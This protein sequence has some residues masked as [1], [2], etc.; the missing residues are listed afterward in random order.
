[1]L[2]AGKWGKQT[3]SIF[4]IYS[5]STAALV[6]RKCLS[7]MLY[8]HVFC[9]VIY[10]LVGCVYMDWIGLVQDRDR[11][12]T[13]VSAVMNLRV[14]WN[15]GS[16]LTSCRPVGFSRRTL[17]HGVWSIHLLEVDEFGYLYMQMFIGEWMQI[18]KDMAEDYR[19]LWTGRK[20]F[21]IIGTR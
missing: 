21:H 20:F 7:L 14:P 5:Y 2:C 9:Y 8:V 1:M 19:A 12:R 18:C 10:Y 11:W 17:H 16:F 4:N 15:A 6:T 3:L 13:L